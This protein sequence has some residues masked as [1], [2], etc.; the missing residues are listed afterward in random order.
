M[1]AKLSLIIAD[2]EEGY[3]EGLVSYLTDN[4][5][6]KFQVSCFTK[7]EYLI[8][9]MGSQDRQVDILLISPDFYKSESLPL[10]KVNTTILLSN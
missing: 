7:P 10:D 5:P 3:V 6:N 2:A 4:H 1:V 8:K 9:Y